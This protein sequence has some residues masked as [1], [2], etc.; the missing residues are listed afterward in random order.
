MWAAHDEVLDRRVALKLVPRGRVGNEQETRL[1][2]EAHALAKLSHPNVVTVHDAD[3]IDAF[4][5]IAMELVEG[6]TLK[7]AFSDPERSMRARIALLSQAA[8]GLHAA[9]AHGLVHRDF[10]PANALLG[11]DGRVRVADFGLARLA[12]D[13][14]P[15]DAKGTAT[16]LAP[17]F[18]E[19]TVTGAILGTPAYM[20]PEH[21]LGRP[22]TASTDQFSFC[23]VAWLAL[24]GVN[25]LANLD[26]A[27]WMAGDASISAPRD[28]GDVPQDVHEALLR[29]LEPEPAA[30]HASMT[31][32]IR[33]LEKALDPGWIAR[34]PRALGGVAVVAV[35]LGGV[36]WLAAP[37]DPCEGLAVEWSAVQEPVR[38][39][40][41]HD[42]TDEGVAAARA[43]SVGLDA[44]ADAWAREASAE[45]RALSSRSPCQEQRHA[46]FSTVARLLSTDDGRAVVPELLATLAPSCADPVNATTVELARLRPRLEAGDVAAV[47]ADCIALEQFD[48]DTPKMRAEILELR[49]AA[50][51]RLGDAQGALEAVRIAYN[52]AERAGD[53]R[54]AAKL[55]AELAVL[56]AV[57]LG[58]PARSRVW[59]D[60][61]EAVTDPPPAVERSL[62]MARGE[63]LEADRAWSDAAN[64]YER[65]AELQRD[66]PPYLD[67]PAEA[68][69]RAARALGL[70]GRPA[71]ARPLADAALQRRR[72][73]Y[74]PRHPKTQAVQDI[75]AR[76]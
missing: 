58:Q 52:N 47:V 14:G 76:L 33:A 8:R 40:S 41:L 34:L 24:Y 54:L 18:S 65:A 42:G 23:V 62:L 10:K 5:Y 48:Q 25:P 55:A 70:A 9:H 26:L 29:G 57:E 22:L 73:L 7:D 69:L 53:Q 13:A 20:S 67:G 50:L 19:L 75:L 32:L 35:G 12:E 44:F 51:R 36:A 17:T 72:H 39:Q 71:E 27:A 38:A 16:P 6:G 59:L 63:I 43:A 66:A 61:A 46:A 21:R 28:A 4:V 30:R 15:S 74:G 56:T 3:R 68:Q 37:D 60:I 1:L 11:R 2:R 45:C 49:G 31:P 64:A